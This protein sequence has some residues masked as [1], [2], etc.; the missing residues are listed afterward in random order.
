MVNQSKLPLHDGFRSEPSDY[1]TTGQAAAACAVTPDAVLKWIRAARLPATRT[2]GGHYRIH[3]RAL[4]DFMAERPSGG[5]AVQY[6]WQFVGTDGDIRPTC[7][8][9]LVYRTRAR[10]CF[11]MASELRGQGRAKLVCHTPCEECDFYR[12]ASSRAG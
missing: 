7:R 10:L 5:R 6:C 12:M 9:C 11:E 1:L 4:M 2:P 3:R 8:S